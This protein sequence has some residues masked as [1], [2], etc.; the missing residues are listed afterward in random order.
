M[1]SACIFSPFTFCGLVLH[2]LQ[3]T[4]ALFPIF[5]KDD[6]MGLLREGLTSHHIDQPAQLDETHIRWRTEKMNENAKRMQKVKDDW[7]ETQV[8]M[9]VGLCFPR[10]PLT[11]FLFKETHLLCLGQHSSQEA[12]SKHCRFGSWSAK[13]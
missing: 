5:T 7:E 13:W 8:C 1:P 6:R 12:R 9:V 2:P 4:Q 11:N 10:F 3:K